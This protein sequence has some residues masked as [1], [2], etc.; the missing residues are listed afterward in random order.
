MQPASRPSLR[1]RKRKRY[2]VDAFKGLED[3]LYS[4]SD[5]GASTASADDDAHD[6]EFGDQASESAASPSPSHL[7]FSPDG[8]DVSGDFD[9]E[10][11]DDEVLRDLKKK[12]LPRAP[13]HSRPPTSPSS[14]TQ[15]F[16]R[17]VL[18]RL[19]LSAIDGH[20]TAVVGP[21]KE[22]VVSYVRSRDRW[23]LAKTLPPRT[24]AGFQN[25][26]SRG[27]PFYPKAKRQN[28]ANHDWA[29]F[30]DHGGCESMKKLQTV[31]ITDQNLAI[32]AYPWL[33]KPSHFIAGP[34]HQR[35][36]FTLQAGSSMSISSTFS[37]SSAASG[38]RSGWI[39]NVGVPV[40]CLEWVPNCTGHGQYLS[41]TAKE[42]LGAARD[43]AAVQGLDPDDIS[44]FTP[45]PPKPSALYIWKIR[46]SNARKE[47]GCIDPSEEPKLQAVIAFDWNGIR[48]LKWCPV[49]DRPAASKAAEGMIRLGLL[50]GVWMDGYLRVLD[51]IIPDT[52]ETAFVH[53]D[54]AAFQAKPPNTICTSLAWLS[55]SSIAVGCANGFV[56]IWNISH[57]LGDGCPRPWFYKLFHHTYITGV[58]SGYPSRPNLLFTNSIDGT[59]RMTDIRHDRAD[60][61]FAMRNRI[62]QPPMTWLDMAQ[63]MFNCDDSNVIHCHF[64]RQYYSRPALIRMEGS[65]LD[66]ASSIHHPFLLVA[67]ADG[68]VGVANAVHRFPSKKKY[69]FTRQYWFKYDWRGG[70]SQAQGTGTG[71]G[72]GNGRNEA[73][74][75]ID[76]DIENDKKEQGSAGVT[77]SPLGRFSEGF[78][79]EDI[80][81][82]ENKGKANPPMAVIYED[83]GAISRVSWNP[84]GRCCTWAV[85]ATHSGLLRIEDLGIK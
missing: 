6:Q 10:P 46:A 34:L 84:N 83:M 77:T 48:K 11:S 44:S 79:P 28:E 73:G 65:V 47:E 1:S 72:T 66:I 85:A 27:S 42:G 68:Y 52:S 60:V 17:G 22:D 19:K 16:S 64:V 32:S 80:S 50:A 62:M 74:V 35:S 37:K 33:Q 38:H 81:H 41:M 54:R 69:L 75:E 5:S 61:V 53:F 4:S 26:G 29:W 59:S 82:D 31:H 18:D 78:K 12:V 21:G 8:S 25:D 9:P 30:Y 49:P 2:T 39:L 58:E 45:R 24:L 23:L 56:A 51:V 76:I 3:V 43:A 20:I 14:T 67:C 70:A 57:G 40:Q 63:C 71:T 55:S 7:V 15:T 13:V 36:E